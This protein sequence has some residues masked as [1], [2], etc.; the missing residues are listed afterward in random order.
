MIVAGLLAMAGGSGIV[1]PQAA[2]FA[3]TPLLR[4]PLAGDASREVLIAS[5]QFETGGTT[6][7]HTHPGEEY[8]TVI[9]GTIE[10]AMDGQTPRRYAAGE[11]YHNVRGVV[12]ETRNIGET[13]ARVVSTLIIDAGRPPSEPAK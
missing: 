10:V 2:G 12:H 13:R 8:A 3:I 5:G 6:G 7:R 1:H 4:T 11:A 9:E